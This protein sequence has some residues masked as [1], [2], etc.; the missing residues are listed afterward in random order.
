LA[1][2]CA[3]QALVMLIANAIGGGDGSFKTFWA[4][5]VNAAVVGSGIASIAVMAIVLLRGQESFATAAEIANAVPGL[6]TFVPAEA[7]PAA[8]FF[9]ALNVFTLWDGALLAAGMTIVAR[10]PRGTATVTALIIV[11][12]TG[13]APLLGSAFGR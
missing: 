11:L 7:K 5:A 4:L 1:A 3:L 8:A 12:S 9:G 6:G 10:L 2:G 13:I